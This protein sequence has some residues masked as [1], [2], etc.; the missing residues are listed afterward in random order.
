M[1]DL[2][3]R[4]T[5][6]AL[7]IVNSFFRRTL[8]PSLPEVKADHPVSGHIA[9]QVS[10]NDR[11][12]FV[13]IKEDVYSST[14][15]VFQISRSK[16]MIKQFR[17]TG[18]LANNVSR[19]LLVVGRQIIASSDDVKSPVGDSWFPIVALPY[20]HFGV[21]C[22]LADERGSR[23][24]A[25]E[26]DSCFLD[27]EDRR[28]LITRELIYPAGYDILISKGE[29]VSGKI[30]E[31]YG[32]Q[33]IEW[34]RNAHPF[35]DKSSLHCWPLAGKI[36]LTEKFGVFDRFGQLFD[37]VIVRA[38]KTCDFILKANDL[39]IHRQSINANVDT[40]ILKG[41]YF[42][43]P[44]YNEIS[45]DFVP[46]DGNVADFTCSVERSELLLASSIDDRPY[47]IPEMDLVLVNGQYYV[48]SEFYAESLADKKESNTD[49]IA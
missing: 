31:I 5:K 32:K 29:S 34:V 17:V 15:A 35:Y 27:G 38:N 28:N 48:T 33:I 6:E 36:K 49:V 42:V 37:K 41:V 2:L 43:Y 39:E 3:Y 19:I 7:G 23:N 4:Y 45:F 21:W 47:I 9:S 18:E 24:G 1:A 12:R 40:E 30:G 26:Y 44:L 13:T 22:Q 14:Y 11:S 25:V 10:H 16:D 20:Q 46:N 8:M